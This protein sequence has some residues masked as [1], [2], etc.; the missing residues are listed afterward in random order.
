MIEM[1]SPP[2]PLRR[3]LRIVERV[4]HEPRSHIIR[5]VVLRGW[6]HG[7]FRFS[8]DAVRLALQ[9]DGIRTLAEIQQKWCASERAP[10]KL[11]PLADFVQ[12]LSCLHLLETTRT[13]NLLNGLQRRFERLGYRP[14]AMAN[15]AYP[16]NREALISEL[17]S[18]FAKAKTSVT[19]GK[20]IRGAFVPHA[21][22]Q[23]SGACAAHVYRSFSTASWP[24]TF[25]IIG[26]DHTRLNPKSAKLH[27]RGLVDLRPFVTPLGQVPVDQLLFNA[28]LNDLPPKKWT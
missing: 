3:D 1:T 26:P 11:E 20:N 12:R 16:G 10:I 14:P 24:D 28:F 25:V 5:D 13:M 6:Q 2:P 27:P 15:L 22:L 9:L 8:T 19:S 4:P 17:E 7:G 23:A 18:C 21:A